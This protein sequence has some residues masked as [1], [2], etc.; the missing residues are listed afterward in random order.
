MEKLLKDDNA[1]HRISPEEKQRTL[2]AVQQYMK[3]AFFY[4]RQIVRRS[5]EPLTPEERHTLN[6]M[7]KDEWNKLDAAQDEATTIAAA[8]RAK[9]LLRGLSPILVK[10]NSKHVGIVTTVTLLAFLFTVILLVYLVLT[11]LNASCEGQDGHER[12]QTSGRT[13]NGLVFLCAVALRD[14]LDQKGNGPLEK[15]K[16]IAVESEDLEMAADIKKEL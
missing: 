6:A 12:Q 10:R 13:E 1:E 8:G 11:C 5:Q 3:Y 2:G 7:T 15:H 16:Q 14:H 9:L 4:E